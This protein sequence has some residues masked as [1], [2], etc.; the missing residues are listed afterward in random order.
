MG[1]RPLSS[2]TDRRRGE[3]GQ[4]LVIFT[5]GLVLICA[6]AALVFDVGQ[7]LL[8][9]RT[10]Q[11]VSDAAALAGARYVVGA[12]YFYHGG[13]AA[14]PPT[15]DA[16]K[17]ACDVASDSGYVDGQGGRIV[18]VDMPPIAPSA[19][20]GLP[21]HI[22]VTIGTTRAS[23]F[24]GILGM[25]TQNTA[26]LG[27]A[28]N[29]SDI[30]L[31][32]SLLA[33][34]PT[35]CG[36]NKINGAVGSIVS[37]NGTV[38]VDSSC[39]T[40]AILL[41]GNGVLTAPEC[42]VVGTIQTS[43]GATNNCTA[44]PTG[45]LVSGDPL[46]NLPPPGKPGLPAA[47][48]ALDSSGAVC[49]PGV[50]ACGTIP[51]GCPGG[52][53]PATEISPQS[54]AFSSNGQKNKA[55]RIFPGYYPGGIETTRGTVYMDPGIYW[56]GGSGV[57]VKSTGGADG[58]L[59]SKAVGDNTGTS[60][61]GGVLIYNTVDPYPSSGCVGA[62]CY[63]IVTLNGGA[64]AALALKPIETGFYKGMVIFVDRTAAPVGT[65]GVDLRGGGSILNVTGT[66]YAPTA[67]VQFNGS[68]TDTVAAQVICYNFQVN[69]SGASFTM[70]YDPGSLFHVK[71]VGLVQ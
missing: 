11:N 47:V 3:R 40:D 44:A 35:G 6:I 63:G 12:T 59:I 39:P 66:V 67:G 68:S 33:L 36:T 50:G 22:E 37:T 38:H 64:G 65:V 45:V 16:V 57:S 26:A 48:N 13:C 18:R 2:T 4:I 71:G 10:E 20:S 49:T 30:A 5:G 28:T 42:D 56:I 51:P 17:A 21:G 43:G 27:V 24:A 1:S 34:D 55:F 70:N 7:N 61:T 53:S 60:P 62:G 41:S 14:A 58:L 52:S 19:F 54:C 15:L 31:P 29:A 46:K 9:R 69:G 8:D 32:Y 25:T 23:F